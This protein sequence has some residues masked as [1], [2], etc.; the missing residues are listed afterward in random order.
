[1]GTSEIDEVADIITS[2]LD[3]AEPAKAKNGPSRAKYLMD[4]GVQEKCRERAAELLDHHPL[5]PQVGLI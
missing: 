4:T 1:M 5:Y 2:V 3:A